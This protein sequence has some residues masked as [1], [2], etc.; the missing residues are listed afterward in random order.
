MKRD[1][2][3]KLLRTLLAVVDHGGFARAARALHVTQPAITQQIQR[4]ESIVQAPLVQRSSRPLRLSLI[5]Q[6]LVD[7]ARRAVLMNDEVL[8]NI[9]GL[10]GRERFR[11]GCSTHF[12]HALWTMLA[13]LSAERPDI[14]CV[15]TTGISPLLAD[16]LA[17]DELDAAVLL[18]TETRRCEMLGR[19]ELGWFGPASLPRQ[20]PFPLAMVGERSALSMRIVETLARHN[21]QWR[22][23][24]WS[25]DPLAV[26]ASVQAGLAYTALPSNVHL[27]DPLLRPASLGPVLEPLPVYL[28]FSPSVRG[29]LVEAIRSAVRETFSVLPLTPA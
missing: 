17:G 7:H 27:T 12:A 2:E 9:S 16:K 15:T 20:P 26:R 10:R 19:L 1:I 21:V 23:V 4:L 11:L 29:P 13:R 3:I 8:A 24:L 14:Q 6:E 25:S 5:G 18:G 28:A 22:S